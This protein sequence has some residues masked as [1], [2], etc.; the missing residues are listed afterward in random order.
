MD[1]FFDDTANVTVLFRVVETA[2]FDGSLAGTGVGLE[3]G[4]FAS[5]L[6][7]NIELVNSSC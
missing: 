3:N 7:L 5:A 2:E 6:R 4:R 1:D